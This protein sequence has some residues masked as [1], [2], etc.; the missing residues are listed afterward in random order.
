MTYFDYS[1]M[2]IK[3]SYFKKLWSSENYR[4]G[5]TTEHLILYQED[6]QFRFKDQIAD[7][8]PGSLVIMA[9]TSFEFCNASS[10]D[11]GSVSLIITLLQFAG[12]IP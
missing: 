3:K 2:E 5:L 1:R 7:V 8:T 11:C 9:H 6:R 4:L 12:F 10:R